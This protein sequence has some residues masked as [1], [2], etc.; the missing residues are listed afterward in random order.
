MQRKSAIDKQA[1]FP[2]VA[3]CLD[4]RTLGRKSVLQIFNSFTRS[5]RS[6][7]N[8]RSRKGRISQLIAD[9]LSGPFS[10]PQ[11]AFCQRDHGLFHSEIYQDLQMLFGLP[12]PAVV[13]CDNEEREID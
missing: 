4:G 7:N 11:I 6:W 8:R 5:H 1:R 9:F 13:C 3:L 2:E 10:I 12:H